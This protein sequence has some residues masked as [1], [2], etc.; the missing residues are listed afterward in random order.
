MENEKIDFL[1]LFSILIKTIFTLAH[2]H[3][4]LIYHTHFSNAI[5]SIF[6]KLLVTGDS[7]TL[8]SMS[9]IEHAHAILK[10]IF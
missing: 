3:L 2:A 9:I 10:A 4:F 5:R 1:K 7:D 8:Y 6:L